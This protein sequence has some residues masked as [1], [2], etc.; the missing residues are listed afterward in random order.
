MI[1]VKF[2]HLSVSAQWQLHFKLQL[3]LEVQYVKYIGGAIHN[4]PQDRC[5]QPSAPYDDTTGRRICE[6]AKRAKMQKG[7]KKGDGYISQGWGV[8]G[9]P[10]V[11]ATPIIPDY[12]Q[13]GCGLW[14]LE[15]K[16]F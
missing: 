16:N 15:F 1:P 14:E 5:C 12:W 13:A 7:L 11:A 3:N 6:H 8:C 4:V 9:P 2:R 10:G